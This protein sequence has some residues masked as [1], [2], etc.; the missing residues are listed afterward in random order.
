MYSVILILVVVQ[1][2][3]KTNKNGQIV[4]YRK[5]LYINLINEYKLKILLILYLNITKF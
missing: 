2:Y 3:I 4:D 5:V 1:R